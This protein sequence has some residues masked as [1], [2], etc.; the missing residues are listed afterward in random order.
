MSKKQTYQSALDELETI[1]TA[2]ENE[3]I[4]IDVLSSKVKRAALLLQF[5][6]TKLR[7][8]EADIDAILKDVQAD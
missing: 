1:I 6:Q 8:T 3:D 5:C 2:I 4:G 7:K